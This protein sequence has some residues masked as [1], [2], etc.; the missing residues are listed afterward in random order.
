MPT[1][2]EKLV[3]NPPQ[4]ISIN[5]TSGDQFLTVAIFVRLYV[6]YATIPKIAP[7]KKA[8]NIESLFIAGCNTITANPI[9]YIK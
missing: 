7:W 9:T 1:P 3:K 4:N 2:E 8:W 5:T 6:P